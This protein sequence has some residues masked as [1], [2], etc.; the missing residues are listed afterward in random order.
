MRALLFGFIVALLASIV[1][2]PARAQSLKVGLESGVTFEN[3]LEESLDEGLEAKGWTFGAVGEASLFEP[4]AFRIELLYSSLDQ[5][6]IV[7]RGTVFDT[8]TY[9]LDL[10]SLPINIRFDLG[11]GSIR[12]Y[13]FGGTTLGVLL[14]AVD[15][16]EEAE[17]ADPDTLFNS[18][19]ATLDLG[20]G[21]RIFLSERIDLGIEARASYGLQT[22]LKE[23]EF[24]NFQRLQGIGGIFYRLF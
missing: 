21:V 7:R 4:L 13:V 1:V 3:N 17:E 10:M 6:V 8:A 14:S 24:M 19:N 5:R 20:A 22:L 16:S 11:E 15:E 2:A 23:G 18:V 9:N 12:P